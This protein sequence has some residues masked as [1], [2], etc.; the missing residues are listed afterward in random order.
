MQDRKDIQ[1][2]ATSTKSVW[3]LETLTALHRMTTAF[4]DLMLYGLVRC[5][6]NPLLPFSRYIFMLQTEATNGVTSCRL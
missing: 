5:G 6:K 4:S 3:I 1:Q 2:N